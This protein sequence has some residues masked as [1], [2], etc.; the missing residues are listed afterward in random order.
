MKHISKMILSA[1]LVLAGV[2]PASAQMS[3]F[4]QSS[5]MLTL[6]LVKVGSQ[7]FSNM[8]FFM[9]PPPQTWQLT[10]KGSLVSPLKAADSAVFDLSTSIVR[11]PVLKIDNTVY[12]DVQLKMNSGGTWS[13]ADLGNTLSTT[14]PGYELSYPIVTTMPNRYCSDAGGELS[15]TFDNG[16]VWKHVADEPCCPLSV[17]TGGTRAET[18]AA[19]IN[20]TSK[21]EVYPNPGDGPT[22][23][24]FRMVVTYTGLVDVPFNSTTT[25]CVKTVPDSVWAGTCFSPVTGVCSAVPS[26]D[27]GTA[28]DCTERAT[29]GGSFVCFKSNTAVPGTC[30][31]DEAAG[32]IP[33]RCVYTKDNNPSACVST[34]NQSSGYYQISQTGVE[35]C[36]VRPVQGVS[37]YP[38]APGR[39]PL[40]VSTNAIASGVGQKA[41]VYITGGLPPYYVTSNYPG[42]VSYELL[43]ESSSV[44]GQGLV[45]TPKRAGTAQ[46]M[47]YDY[48]RDMV[49]IEVKSDAAAATPV[50]IGPSSIDVMEGTFVDLYVMS[51]VPPI[52][53]HNPQN[54]WVDAPAVIEKVPS[55]VRILMKKSTGDV[56]MPLYFTDAAGTVAFITI[57]IKPCTGSPSCGSGGGGIFK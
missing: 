42:V 11:V 29:S 32:P 23:G 39:G 41:T 57:K 5:N 9:P 14:T 19:N 18:I 31:F 47:V 7:Y 26:H 13:V 25:N 16:Q 10:S 37:N 36:V 44:T 34:S 17:T 15:Y 43:P 1:I 33:N 21:V 2:L 56:E 24:H 22:Q 50:I 52:T 3:E 40:A 12:S 51:G 45:V 28:A 48:N 49:T 38:V 27:T 30:K 8:S 53:V 54:T 46:L 6:Q 55:S 20:G 4:K 35:T